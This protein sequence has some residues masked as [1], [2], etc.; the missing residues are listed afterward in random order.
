MI[1]LRDN[2]PAER[3][4][5]VAY[6]LIAINV[7]VFLLEL[8]YPTRGPVV[9]DVGMQQLVLRSPLDQAVWTF[10][11][12]PVAL[13]NPGLDLLP[14]TPIP[15]WATI[16]TSMFMH[17]GWLHIGGNMLYMWIF[18]DNVEDAMGHGRFLGFYLVG[19][20]IAA[21]V[22]VATGPSSPVPMVGASGAIAAVMGAYL[23]L[24]PRA[25]VLSAVIIIF[26][27]RLIEIPAVFFLGVWIFLQLIQ[28]P[29]GGGVAFF[30]HIGG[31][32]FG[33]GAAKLLAT[34]RHVRR[35]RPP[36]E[37]WRDSFRR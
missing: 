33:A 25:R 32:V 34:H 16:F 8:V 10:G 35:I 37:A 29:S 14:H 5:Y 9:V 30:A 18:A 13:L 6:T 28:A 17:G 3:T 20:V 11:L 22:Q 21:A 2:I 4:P 1:P 24:Y 36:D 27:I 31:F 7:V 12:R 23:V 19:G 15:E 26:F